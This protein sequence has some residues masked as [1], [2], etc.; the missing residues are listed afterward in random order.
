M[1]SACRQETLLAQLQQVATV[2]TT[3]PAAQPT[4][5]P[6]A[7]EKDNEQQA[8]ATPCVP[9]VRPNCVQSCECMLG[10][11]RTV[12]AARLGCRCTPTM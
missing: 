5:K 10:M 9:E 6:L 12:L 8:Q 2:A 3:Q 11:L 1:H 4:P 7:N